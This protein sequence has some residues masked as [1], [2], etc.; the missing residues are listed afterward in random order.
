MNRLANVMQSQ[1]KDK[2]PQRHSLSSLEE[3]WK[4][5]A[6]WG[7]GEGDPIKVPAKAPSC[8]KGR[9]S[10][11]PQLMEQLIMTVRSAGLPAPR[12]GALFI[13][14]TVTTAVTVWGQA[15]Y[16]PSLHKLP[17]II[18]LKPCM[19]KQQLVFLSQ[20]QTCLWK[21]TAEFTGFQSAQSNIADTVVIS[22]TSFYPE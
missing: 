14:Q 13:Y 9:M 2:R 20:V 15:Y 3:L 17:L 4:L 7:G 21:P 11:I 16:P 5:T 19:C 22:A 18:Y 6:V 8:P 1:A 12:A 10:L